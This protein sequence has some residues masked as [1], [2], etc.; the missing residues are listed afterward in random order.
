MTAH[1]HHPERPDVVLEP[2]AD[3]PE[4]ELPPSS[5][6]RRFRFGHAWRTFRRLI[7][8]PRAT[9]NAIEV[10]YAI[11]M[12]DF[13]RAFRRFAASS[14]GRQLLAARPSLLDALGDRA[15]LERLPDASLGRAYLADLGRNGFAADG[16][17][18]LQARVGA[19]LEAEDPSLALDPARAWFRDRILLVH[20]LAHVLTGYGTD[21]LGEATLL[22][23]DF[24]QSAGFANGLLTFGAAFE[25]WQELGAA[26]V[27]YARRAWRRGRRARWLV[28]LPFEQLVGLTVET[29][30]ALAEIEPAARA[31]PRGILRGKLTTAS[32]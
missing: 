22:A 17:V 31:H 19:R 30:R 20:D 24:A 14:E 18:A 23:F 8:D 10:F 29:V 28:T 11:G 1:L 25:V 32:A 7:A 21:E 26:W 4:L 3:E 5:R 15:A 16:L 27:P 13:E 6:R 9:E 2:A 12:G